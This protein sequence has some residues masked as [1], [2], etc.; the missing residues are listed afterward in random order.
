MGS[1]GRDV[2][3][4]LGPAPG[5]LAFATRIALICALTTLAAEFY[6]LPDAA[7]MVYVVFFLNKP[8]RATSLVTNLVFGVLITLV[9]GLI[10][11]VSRLVLDLPFWRFV[12]IAVISFSLLFL[13]SASKLRPVGSIIALIVG[14][15]L[16]ELGLVP[17]GEIGVRALLYA[18]LFVA[19]P[20][21][22][23]IIVN[24]VLAPAP[25]RVA[26]RALAHRLAVCATV[27]RGS[28]VSAREALSELLGEGAGQTLAWL[29]LAD[30]ERT[31]PPADIAALRQAAFS[32]FAIALLVD[33]AAREPKATPPAEARE[34]IAGLLDDM[35]QILRRGRYPLEVALPLVVGEE[36]LA[37]PARSLLADLRETLADF[38]S[39]LVGD[40]RP[41]APAN[42]GF[43]LPD[44]FT[45][46]EHVQFALKTTGAAL[47]CYL[48]YT[49]LDWPN[50]HTCFITCYIVGLSTT[51]E[52][53]QK[54]ALRV[55]GALIGGAAGIVA[56]VYIVP[57]L[58]S[59]GALMAV[60]F[61]GALASAWIAVGDERIAYV[62]FQSAFAFFLCV[63]QGTAPAFDMALARD[64]VIGIL[65]G[66]IV[67]YLGF[68]MVWPVSVARRIDPGL[69][70]LIAD[71][72]AMVAAAGVQTRRVLAAQ[73]MAAFGALERNLGLIAYEPGQIRP[74][75]GWLDGR[76]AIAGEAA[77]L[78]APLLLGADRS[79][80]LAAN[81]AVRL[82]DLE[83]AV[84]EGAE[85]GARH[86]FA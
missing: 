79:P 63:L 1:W 26:E 39:P 22:I 68:V 69:R 46:P 18:W 57:H 41:K 12:A 62:G 9:V 77:D 4:L 42:G 24:L 52:T 71:L 45:N 27:L 73:A 13:T 28:D 47:I 19:T 20:A 25:R 40:I 82:S 17:G 85:E 5:R 70:T 83:K 29:R 48:F 37:E 81:A 34:T 15:G 75:A 49:Q 16:D 8:D 51:A 35:A 80:Q 7:L 50:V 74:T 6:R 36:A 21:A 76:R 58:A 67:T 54:G 44:A 33:F 64:R 60:V 55:V 86:A 53:V 38:A 43:F 2:L 78:A 61:A 11:L 32:T 3:H 84:G 72:L 66:D 59:V 65:I 23:S 10:M 56:L 14:Y 31:S 30:V